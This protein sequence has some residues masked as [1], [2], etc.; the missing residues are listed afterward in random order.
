MERV[1]ANLLVLGPAGVGKSS[2]I[3]S[4]LSISSGILKSNAY[5]ASHATGTVTTRLSSFRGK[6][7]LDNV[8]L[9]DIPGLLERVNYG[10]NLGNLIHLIDGHVKV[11]YKF[12]PKE[13]ITESDPY[14]RNE[15]IDRI[16]C[17]VFVMDATGLDNLSNLYKTKIQDIQQVLIEKGIIECQY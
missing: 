3:N 15:S 9:H 13:S 6:G 12:N 11:G 14:F 1:M 16:N 5:T 8:Q 2:F 4:V 17:A 10:F 7:G